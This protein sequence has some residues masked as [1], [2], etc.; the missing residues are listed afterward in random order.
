V[1]AKPGDIV[2]KLRPIVPDDVQA[3]TRKLPSFGI[4]VDAM[5]GGFVCSG[6]MKAEV[7]AETVKS[8]F[9]GE[10]RLGKLLTRQQR[11]FYDQHAPDGVRPRD[12]RLLGPITLLKLKFTP[13]DYGRRLVAELWIYPDGSR[14]LELSTKCAPSEAF[15]A[16]AEARAYLGTRGVDLAG[17]QQTKTKAALEFFAAE[18]RAASE[19]GG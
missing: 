10:G 6:T 14:I 8:L 2:V 5:P 19:E 16:S 3:A 7:K 12:L 15:E 17:E 11:D 13:A 1:Q 18:L 4:E 9:A